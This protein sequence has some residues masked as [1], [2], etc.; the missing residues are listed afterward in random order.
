MSKFLDFPEDLS[1]VKEA[2]NRERSFQ[3]YPWIVYGETHRKIHLGFNGEDV[4]LDLEWYNTGYD[5]QFA[6]SDSLVRLMV[7]LNQKRNPVP[8]AKGERRKKY[9]IWIPAKHERRYFAWEKTPAEL[10]KVMLTAFD[11]TQKERLQAAYAEVV[12]VFSPAVEHEDVHT[13][14]EDWTESRL[15]E[16]EEVSDTAWQ[17]IC[18]WADT[19]WEGGGWVHRDE[20]SFFALTGTMKLK[21]HTYKHNPGDPRVLYMIKLDVPE[22]GVKRDFNLIFDE[23]MEV[24]ATLDAHLLL[25]A[26]KHKED[27]AY[28]SQAAAIR[29]IRKRIKTAR[30]DPGYKSLAEVYQYVMG[31]LRT[32][33][34]DEDVHTDTSDYGESIEGG[35]FPVDNE[36]L[37]A[38]QLRFLRALHAQWAREYRK[39]KRPQLTSR[40]WRKLISG[41]NDNYRQALGQI[42]KYHWAEVLKEEEPEDP[43]KAERPSTMVYLFAWN[44]AREILSSVEHEDVHTDTGNWESLGLMLDADLTALEE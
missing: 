11:K 23:G 12:R 13:D 42:L 33:V 14:T 41:Y 3:G 9:L 31:R 34:E 16:T 20:V 36:K 35:N 8:R 38:E 17:E 5:A 39:N 28:N 37:T 19:E 21:F 30:T 2:L 22:L 7:S 10:P 43:L 40:E 4:S 32:P 25:Y 1:G 26:E 44:R 18:R 27:Y 29:A 24:P 6:S 15:N